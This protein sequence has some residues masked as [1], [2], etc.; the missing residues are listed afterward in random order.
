MATASCRKRHTTTVSSP[1]QLSPHHTSV[2]L[3]PRPSASRGRGRASGRSRTIPVSFSQPPLTSRWTKA[4]HRP[5]RD[6]FCFSPPFACLLLP[7]LWLLSILPCF[8]GFHRLLVVDVFILPILSF[9]RFFPPPP[10]PSVP[11]PFFVV[12]V[13]LFYF[14]L[15]FHSLSPDIT[16]YGRLGSKH[17]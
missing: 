5:G 12:V 2:P 7:E 11:P 1:Q 3:S 8:G 17:H 13:V 9:S 10:P 4:A 6:L 14:L 16:L 15:F